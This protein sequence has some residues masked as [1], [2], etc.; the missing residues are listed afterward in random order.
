MFRAVCAALSAAALC[1][2]AS[3]MNETTHP[4][5]VETLTADGAAVAGADCKLTNDY[6]TST[7]KSGETSQVRRSSKDLALRERIG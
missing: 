3:V 5:K 4:I 1:G 6:G 2:C 7:A